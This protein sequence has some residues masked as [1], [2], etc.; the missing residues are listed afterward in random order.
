M[1]T[2]ITQPPFG[3]INVCKRLVNNVVPGHTKDLREN[4]SPPCS[5]YFLYLTDK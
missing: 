1:D 4:N 5:I 2:A 3:I